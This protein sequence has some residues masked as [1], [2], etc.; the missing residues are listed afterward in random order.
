LVLEMADVLEMIFADAVL[1]VRGEPF[2]VGRRRRRRGG[3]TRR[4]RRRLSSGRRRRP[5]QERDRERQGKEPGH[6]NAALRGYH[7]RPIRSRTS[8][9]KKIDPAAMMRREARHASA[10][11]SSTDA[12][13]LTG[14]SG[15]MRRARSAS[16]SGSSERGLDARVTM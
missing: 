8:P 1:L 13:T 9:T 2:G 6:S 11:A 14:T 3:L 15:A 16:A 10:S 7:E 4:R 5:Q 12:A